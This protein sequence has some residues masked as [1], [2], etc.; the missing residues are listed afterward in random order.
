MGNRGKPSWAKTLTAAL[1]VTVIGAVAL[2]FGLITGAI[3]AALLGGGLL[4]IAAA[5]SALAGIDYL[6]KRDYS[7][8]RSTLQ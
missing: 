6:D 7:S 3:I 1:W 8:T 5:I 2:A 4:A